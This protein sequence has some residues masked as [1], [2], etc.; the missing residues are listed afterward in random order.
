MRLLEK[1]GVEGTDEVNPKSPM[2]SSFADL[3]LGK[4][5]LDCSAC[6]NSGVESIMLEAAN[7]DGTAVTD[8]AAFA[9]DLAKRG[10]AFGNEE[11]TD[12]A[13]VANNPKSSSVEVDA[14]AV[15]AGASLVEAVSNDPKSLVVTV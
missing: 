6:A 9:D 3:V 8:M 14:A 5:A 12:V 13:G 1:A 4:M 10:V 15:A 2:R 11:D 7:P